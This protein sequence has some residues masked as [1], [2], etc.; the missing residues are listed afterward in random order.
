MHGNNNVMKLFLSHEAE[1]PASDI[2]SKLRNEITEKFSL[3]S[4]KRNEAYY[5]KDVSTLCIITTCV[6]ESFLKNTGWK[7]RIHYSKKDMITD[8]RLNMNYEKFIVS[9]VQAQ[10]QMYKLNIIDSITSFKNK[11]PSLDFNSELLI[12]DILSIM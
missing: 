6:S 11:Y 5:G 7:N 8:I 9:D 1:T 2:I 12:C 4:M 10:R 3:L